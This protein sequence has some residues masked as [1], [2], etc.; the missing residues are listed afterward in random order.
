MGGHGK[1]QPAANVWTTR[2]VFV[3][4]TS[5][6]LV[7]PAAINSPSSCGRINLF[8]YGSVAEYMKGTLFARLSIHSVTSLF[9]C[10][11]R[12]SGFVQEKKKIT[13]RRAYGLWPVC[14]LLYP[15]GQ[16]K[17]ERSILGFHVRKPRSEYEGHAVVWDSGARVFLHS[18][19]IGIW[20]PRPGIELA[21]S[22]SAAPC[23][24]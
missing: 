24:T 13:I 11:S 3:R 15:R 1:P 12:Q 2:L 6:S 23:H 9:S 21:T 16:K 10:R 5:A 8:G 7:R 4:E 18:A 14:R 19:P 17:N 20:P 22:C